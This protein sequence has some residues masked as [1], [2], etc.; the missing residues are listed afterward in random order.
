[1]SQ[2]SGRRQGNQQLGFEICPHRCGCVITDAA[3]KRSRRKPGWMRWAPLTLADGH[4]LTHYHVKSVEVHP[5]CTAACAQF[6]S[7]PRSLTDAEF[8]AWV[9]HLGHHARYHI[10]IPQRYHHLIP[11]IPLEEDYSGLLPPHPLP[12]QPIPNLA[13]SSLHISVPSVAG[14]SSTQPQASGS[15]DSQK[16]QKKLLFIEMPRL[17]EC[18]DAKG[19]KGL[20][21]Y[22]R[23]CLGPNPPPIIRQ[24]LR[25]APR[26]FAFKEHVESDDSETDVESYQIHD[27]VGT[28]QF[29]TASN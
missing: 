14:P 19:A 11:A 20:V 27:A 13:M 28:F 4:H 10:H 5:N 17:E 12:P 21:S 26:G 24:A 16:R 7:S 9:P 1:M 18:D 23:Y 22:D 2:A 6:N 3:A 25:D 29:N 8:T 15:R